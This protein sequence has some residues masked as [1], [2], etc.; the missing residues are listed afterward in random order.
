LLALF[1]ARRPETALGAGAYSPECLGI[2]ATTGLIPAQ[3]YTPALADAVALGAPGLVRAFANL[4]SV[5]ELERNVN[6]AYARYVAERHERVLY[7][8]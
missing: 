2:D 6:H 7:S 4:S 3:Q 8:V 1:S 5:M